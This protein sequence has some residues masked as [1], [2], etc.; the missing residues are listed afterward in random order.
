MAISSAIPSIHIRIIL[1]RSRQS[2]SSMSHHLNREARTSSPMMSRMRSCSALSFVAVVY[3]RSEYSLDT[4]VEANI[5]HYSRCSCCH[6]LAVHYT[7]RR[8]SLAPRRRC[9]DARTP[10]LATK[11]NI[12]AT[13]QCLA[14]RYP[15]QG[16]SIFDL[17][18][19][20][21]TVAAAWASS[22]S[23]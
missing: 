20:Y 15:N 9:A 8:S 13:I 14:R 21:G 1:I 2:H 5:G 19:H 23:I 17:E 10:M 7:H 6:I 12:V 3:C 22:S 18:D 4:A 11:E 16:F